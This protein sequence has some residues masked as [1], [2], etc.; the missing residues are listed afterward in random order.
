MKKLKSFLHEKVVPEFA[1]VATQR[2]L[3]AI[4]NGI[5]QILPF[6]IAG[7]IAMI[8]I[9]FPIGSGS[10]DTLGSIM[11]TTIRTW[12]YYLY[13]WNFC[14]LGL[15]AGI[16]IGSELAK[17]YRL[18]PTIGATLGAISLIMWIMPTVIPGSVADS[19]IYGRVINIVGSFDAS[20][21]L[22]AVLGSIISVEI[23]R[24][25]V[26][27]NITIKLPKQVP[28]QVTQA[29]IAIIPVVVVTI[30]YS[31]IR[32]LL[33]FDLRSFMNQTLNPIGDFVTGNI[34]G[35]ILINF[36]I[37][38]TWWFGINLSGMF[39]A[40]VRPF[41]LQGLEHNAKVQEDSAN[42][43]YKVY[44]EQFNQSFTQAGGS[45]ASLGMVLAIL[46][47]AKGKSNR[48]VAYIALTPGLFNINE[49]LI[50][51]YPIMLNP[52]FF[53][54]FIATPIA[55]TLVAGWL[56]PLLGIHLISAAPWT[57]P[58]PI[59]ALLASGMQWQA[60]VLAFITIG[61]SFGIYT[62]FVI[63]HDRVKIR[64]ENKNA[65]VKKTNIVKKV[66]A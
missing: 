22:G 7:S 5:V 14:V 49:P 50:F 12:I 66:L 54:P 57:L 16:A 59:F 35:A 29:F 56:V 40:M 36:L 27:Y 45:G 1:K 44:I 65:D 18:N 9:A 42:G 47:F 24:V 8:I 2:H 62:P 46:I 48:S 55:I 63:F 33:G 58:T 31:S 52:Y 6:V 43:E 34:G 23:Y 26:K 4:R 15:I 61:I 30:I 28:V 64:E 13:K 38:F 10:G 32:Y 20:T 39:N 37:T 25:I 41:W 3:L 53:I 51:G 60:M 17:S 21:M 11:P 19:P